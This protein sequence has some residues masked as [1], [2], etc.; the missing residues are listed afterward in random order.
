MGRCVCADATVE[1]YI[2][3][4]IK[5]RQW[6]VGLILGQLSAQKDFVLCLARTPEA[7]EDEVCEESETGL[8]EQLPSSTKR[9]R[10]PVHPKTLD[11]ADELWVA[12]H[13]K[14]VTRMLPGGLDVIGIFAV[15]PTN[16]LK[17]SQAKL[18]QIVFAAEKLLNKDMPILPLDTTKERIILQVDSLTSKVTCCSVEVSNAKSTLKPAEWRYSGPNTWLRLDSAVAVDVTVPIATQNFSLLK[19]MQQGILP[20]CHEIWNS[21]TLINGVVREDGELLA[22]SSDA[23]KKKNKDN[24]ASAVDKFHIDFLQPLQ[25]ATSLEVAKVLEMSKVISV[26]GIIVTRAFVHKKATVKESIEAMKTDIVRSLVVR[27]ELLREDLELTDEI[28]A[29]ESRQ[30]HDTPVRVFIPAMGVQFCDYKFQ[31]EKKEEV[32]QR[33]KELTDIEVSADDMEM[34]CEHPA[35]ESDWVAAS[36]SEHSLSSYSQHSELHNK[37]RLAFV[38]SLVVS[39]LVASAAAVLAYVSR[40]EG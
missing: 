12:T 22:P 21:E 25:E 30:L 14:Q 39:A 40:Q 19:C 13:A 26:R 3:D 35:R 1:V 38:V 33:I 37:P 11:A 32:L 4:L 34:D 8:E 31:D 16:M 20:F 18:R 5:R 10:K 2:Q 7:A 27:C 24:S 28:S 36:H 29:V 17:D 23:K 15:A 6:F 9:I